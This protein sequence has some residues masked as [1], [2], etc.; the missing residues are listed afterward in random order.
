M[1]NKITINH[2]EK[3]DNPLL[4][5]II[6][7]FKIDNGKIIT[8]KEIT[9]INKQLVELFEQTSSITFVAK[10]KDNIVGYVSGHII[11][12]PLIV[13]KECYITE[14]LVIKEKRGLG[15]GNILLKNIENIARE[16]GCTRLMLDNPK[17]YESYKRKYYAKNGFEER[18]NF[19]NFVKQIKN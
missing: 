11:N 15:I 17:F 10:E 9:I 8:D 18:D 12:F 7:N 2:L 1:N 3:R 16:K 19:A 4:T 14:L 5:K 6:S 13:G